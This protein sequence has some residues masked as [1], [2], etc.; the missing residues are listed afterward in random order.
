M[1][2]GWLSPRMWNHRYGAGGG[3]VVG[4]NSCSI[5]E[6]SVLICKQVTDNLDMLFLTWKMKIS[7]LEKN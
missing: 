6:A 2:C 3:E 4:L 5:Q 7:N 1:T